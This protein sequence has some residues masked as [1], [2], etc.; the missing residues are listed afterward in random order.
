MKEREKLLREVEYYA[1]SGGYPDRETFTLARF[2]EGA[3]SGVAE[4]AKRAEGIFEAGYS[5]KKAGARERK[6]PALL[7][8]LPSAPKKK[9]EYVLSLFGMPVGVMVDFIEGKRVYHLIEPHL[10]AEIMGECRGIEASNEKGIVSAAKKICKKHNIKFSEDVLKN[11]KYYFKRNGGFGRIGVLLEDNNVHAIYCDGANKPIWVD[12]KG[13]KIK[14]NFDLGK[15]E[16]EHVIRK[17]AEMSKA[18][19]KENIIDFTLEG[20]RYQVTRGAGGVSSRFIIT[21]LI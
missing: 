11:M 4:E 2:I 17:V 9:D 16:I 18:K 5:E 10:E 12:Y 6:L 14:T 3:F 21:K 7:K 20:I 1:R 15:E 19:A 8:K 13:E